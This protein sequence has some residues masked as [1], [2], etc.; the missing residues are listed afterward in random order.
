MSSLKK[1][2]GQTALYGLSSI[3]GRALNFLLVPFYTSVLTI[4][5]FGI[6]TDVYVYMAFLNIVYLFG[7]ET[8][9]FRFANES[10][11]KTAFN[12]AFSWILVIGSIF[13]FSFI[14][15]SQKIA[16]SLSYPNQSHFII[17]LS[18]ILLIDSISAIP[19]SLIHI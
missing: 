6:M 8:T 3:V 17:F 1:L 7:M 10:D 5:D 16:T 14:A 12:H 15:F 11:E 4:H 19:L 9:Y 13:S 18:L 2:L